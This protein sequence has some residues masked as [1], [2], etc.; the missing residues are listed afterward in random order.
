MIKS[1]TVV[2]LF[3][4]ALLIVS[5][6]GLYAYLVNSVPLFGSVI[7][8]NL[9]SDPSKPPSCP[10]IPVEI[11]GSVVVGSKTLF[12]LEIQPTIVSVDATQVVLKPLG[13]IG[14]DYSVIINLVQGTKVIS[15]SGV[16]T[17][18]L[19]NAAPDRLFNTKQP[20]SVT[21]YAQDIDCNKQPDPFNAQLSVR[22]EPKGQNTEV[23]V[24]N[25]YFDGSKAVLT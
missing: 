25:L 22:L 16:I 18:T 7:K 9:N 10:A 12:S 20:Y 1:K 17:G 21:S 23:V 4:A 5:G 6:V 13:I 19:W 2:T 14:T 11:L 8:S 15:S 24:K 3:I